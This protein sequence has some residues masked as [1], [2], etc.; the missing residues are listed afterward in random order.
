MLST[1]RA[2]LHVMLPVDCSDCGLK[3]EF[4]PALNA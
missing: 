4:D 2:M 3:I 1:F